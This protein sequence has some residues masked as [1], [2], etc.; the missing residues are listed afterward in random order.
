ML[1]FW[2][3][4]RCLGNVVNNLGDCHLCVSSRRSLV[5]SRSFVTVVHRLCL[6]LASSALAGK[7]K[8]EPCRYTKHIKTG[9]PGTKAVMSC[10]SLLQF[11]TWRFWL[12]WLATRIYVW[13]V[14]WQLWYATEPGTV[15]KS[16]VG[17]LHIRGTVYLNQLMAFAAVTAPALVALRN[18]PTFEHQQER[19]QQIFTFISF[20][21][22]ASHPLAIDPPFSFGCIWM[23]LWYS[24]VMRSLLSQSWNETLTLLLHVTC[25]D[26]KLSVCA[27]FGFL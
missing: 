8:I 1:W 5:N 27:F 12:N 4:Q 9:C 16:F 10:W 23:V 26:L 24:L 3:F 13:A 15:Y 21:V 20:P 22:Q 18:T 19:M 7:T 11:W 2:S 17:H 25:K 6:R 14:K